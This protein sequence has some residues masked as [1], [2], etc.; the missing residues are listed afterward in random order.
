MTNMR[1]ELA[2][3]RVKANI[4]IILEVKDKDDL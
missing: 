3:F 4:L 1:G 2:I